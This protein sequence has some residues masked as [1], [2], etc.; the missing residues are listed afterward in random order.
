M[1]SKDYLITAAEGLHARPATNLVRLGKKYT[2]IISLKKGEKTVKLN[3]MLNILSMAL[4]GG[5][6]ITIITEGEDEAEA[7]RAIDIFFTEELKNL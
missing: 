5:D 6:T 2:S 1:I 3:S 7:A 4:K